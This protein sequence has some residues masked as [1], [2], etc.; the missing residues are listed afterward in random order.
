MSF[1]CPG[2]IEIGLL[3]LCGDGA[4]HVVRADDGDL[5]GMVAVRSGVLAWLDVGAYLEVCGDGAQVRFDDLHEVVGTLDTPARPRARCAGA[6]RRPRSR[7][8]AAPAAW[9]AT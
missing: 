3:G 6:R 5:D 7:G 9:A 8:R 2:G 1:T 4:A